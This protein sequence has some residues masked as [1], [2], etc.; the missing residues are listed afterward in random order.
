MFLDNCFGEGSIGKF[1]LLLI[2][3]IVGV[4]CC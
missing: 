1:D 4:F 3:V 2:E